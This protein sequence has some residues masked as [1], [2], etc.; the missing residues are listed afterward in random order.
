MNFETR[1]NSKNPFGTDGSKNSNN[2]SVENLSVDSAENI[3]IDSAENLCVDS[4]ENIGIDSAENLCVDSV[5][6]LNSPR[7]SCS[8]KAPNPFSSSADESS[9]EVA[10]EA[11]HLSFSYPDSEPILK[12]ISLKIYKG[13][14]TVIAGLNGSGKSTFAYHLNGLLL[15]TSGKMMVFG[16]ETSKKSNL[17]EIRRKVGIVFQNPYLQFVGSTVEEDIAFGPENLGLNRNE[18]KNRVSQVL[19]TFHLKSL[20]N[21]D[22]ASLSGGEAQAVAIAGTVAM[23]PECIILDE[24]A[25][26]LDMAAEKRVF[27]MIDQLQKRGKTLVYIS[28]NPQDLIK[29]DRIIVFDKGEIAFDGNLSQYIDSEKYPLPD[30]I[31][32]FKK[33]R[34]GGIPVSEVVPNPEKAASEILKLI[35]KTD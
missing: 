7:A 20:A 31:D 23:D 6:S 32:L 29:A 5:E 9:K 17:S 10:F 21:Q 30:L 26:M 3:G 8:Y 16:K 13:E 33:L 1:N 4:T 15:P 11:V 24:V 28:H 27:N 19:E 18:I 12:N 2:G 25:S 34:D 35:S 22:P 14:F